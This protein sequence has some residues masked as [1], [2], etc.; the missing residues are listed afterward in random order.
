[1]EELSLNPTVENIYL[2]DHDSVRIITE[3]N[4]VDLY[5]VP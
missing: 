4:N 2:S 5:T 1:M 3:K